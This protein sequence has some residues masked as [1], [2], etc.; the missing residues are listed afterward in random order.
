MNV[1]P[2]RGTA[3]GMAVSLLDSRNRSSINYYF[4]VLEIP[5]K[6][7]NKNFQRMSIP[8]ILVF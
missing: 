8:S 7:M 1:E 4:R 2:R 6:G 3:T 5:D